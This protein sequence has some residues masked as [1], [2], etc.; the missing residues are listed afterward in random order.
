LADRLRH[1]LEALHEEAGAIS[2]IG[3]SLG[4]VFARELA[5]AR[6]R[7]VR[8]VITL[9]SPLYG[10]PKTSTNAWA[11]YCIVNKEH[12]VDEH[13]RGTHPPPVPCTSIYSRGDGVVAWGTSVEHRGL[14]TDSIEINAASH[15][16]LGINP[17][18]WYAI[19]DRLAQPA[20]AWQPFRPRGVT[21]LAFPFNSPERERPAAS[22]SL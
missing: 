14:H 3:W 6:P 4:G 19:G 7:L 15:L 16:G 18:A 20:Q 10:A 11:V 12:R 8:Q 21:R 9:G 17:L 5:R 1:R 22:P 2:V 13:V